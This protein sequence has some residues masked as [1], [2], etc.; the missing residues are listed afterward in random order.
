MNNSNIS[1]QETYRGNYGNAESETSKFFDIHQVLE[2]QKNGRPVNSINL[3]EMKKGFFTVNDNVQSFDWEKGSFPIMTKNHIQRGFNEIYCCYP[4][5]QKLVIVGRREN[6]IEF[7]LKGFEGFS[8]ILVNSQFDPFC[9]FHYRKSVKV[10]AD[11]KFVVLRVM[12]H[13]ILIF[14]N[15]KKLKKKLI[16]IDERVYK[17]GLIISEIVFVHQSNKLFVFFE[18]GLYTVEKIQRKNDIS[19]FGDNP[20]ECSWLVKTVYDYEELPNFD[21]SKQTLK[22][23]RYFNDPQ[24]FHD[25]FVVSLYSRM[26]RTTSL[27][28]FSENQYAKKLQFYSLAKISSS[29]N[30]FMSK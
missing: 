19:N 22:A 28:L 13:K 5:G 25:F 30:S 6:F 2:Y 11:Q 23:V 1:F 3:A 7:V 20:D 14:E 15:S 16:L 12:N 4:F 26:R 18:S 9:S 21:K 29:K 17:E 27:E 8:L 24:T 10:S